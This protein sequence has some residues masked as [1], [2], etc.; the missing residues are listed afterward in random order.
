ML[1]E[2]HSLDHV[3]LS[4][5]QAPVP[6]SAATPYDYF[7]VNAVNLD[8]HG[9]L[10]IDARNTWTV[11]D[12]DRHS[13]KINWRLGGKA[14]DFTLG[15]GVA[16]AWQHNPLPAGHDTIRLFDNEAAPAV[17]QHSRVIW[18]HLDQRRK[19]ATLVRSIEHPDGLLAGSQGNSQALDDGHTFVG[20]GATGRVS[21]FDEDGA[22][23]FDASVPTGWD[24]Y[25]GYRAEW[26][27]DPDADPVAT[28]Q[29]AG[30]STTVHAIWNGATDVSDW[31]VLAGPDASSLVAGRGRRVERARHVDHRRRLARRRPGRRARRPRPHARELHAGRGR[32]SPARRAGCRRRGDGGARPGRVRPVAPG[33]TGSRA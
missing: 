27:G 23:L 7:H 19:T 29:H 15:P 26:E 18:I 16:F 20:W 5:S 31:R 32:L 13:G 11:Y 3:P 24:T 14:S 1:F 25:R 17:R 4:E 6:T 22:L 2:W 33:R 28:A 9:D 30:A 10:L 21:E 12:V 8:E